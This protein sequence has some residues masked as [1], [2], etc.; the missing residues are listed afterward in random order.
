MDAIARELMTEAE[1][2]TTFQPLRPPAQQ[3]MLEERLRAVR[4]LLI[5]DNI[6]SVTGTHL[7]IRNTLPE[8]ER[9]LL[10]DFL[11]QLAGGRT[12]VLLGSRGGEDWLAQGTFEDNVHDLGGLHPEAASTLADRI[13]ERH[14][15][16]RYR[17]DEN[18]QWLLDL[19]AGYPMAMEVVLA[20]LARQTPTQVLDALRTGDEAI[21]MRSE[22]KTESILRCIDYS[23]SNLSSEAQ[24]LL[25]CL[26]PFTSVLNINMLS[27]Y[28]DQLRQQPALEHPCFDLWEQVLQEAGDW[29]LLAPHPRVKGFVRL[30][31]ILPYFLR[32]RLDNPDQAAIRSAIETAFR[33]HYDDMGRSIFGLLQSKVAGEK[34]VGQLLAQLEYNNLVTALNLALNDHVSIMNPY[35]ALSDYLHWTRD[36]RRGLELS[37]AVLAS[38][39]VFPSESLSGALARDLVAVLDNV[40]GL[41][42]LTK[43]YAD[44]EASYRKALSVCPDIKGVEPDEIR[45]STAS[46]YHQL[47]AVAYEQR[48]WSKAIHYYNESLKIKKEFG[49]RFEQA[50]T[51]HQ[52]GMVSREQGLWAKAEQY[53]QKALEIKIEFD[54]RYS[55]AT[56]Y[57]EL[58]SLAADQLRWQQAEQY[59]LKALEILIAFKDRHYEAAVYHGLGTVAAEQRDLRRAENYFQ[60]ALAIYIELNERYEQAGTYHMLGVVA[61]AQ[62]QWAQAKQYYQQALEIKIEFNDCYSQASTYGQLGLLAGDKGLWRQARQYLLQ[63]LE[64]FVSVGEADPTTLRSLTRLWLVSED[65]SL[66]AA[67]AQV[68][69][70]SQGEAEEL[71]LELASN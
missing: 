29:G 5:L 63:A 11:S 53:Y 61:Q 18:V 2:V 13:I 54:D 47:G 43:R 34:H 20:N 49:D 55:Q 24:Q 19:L 69:G 17:G 46:I 45:R 58:G 6:E 32:S 39:E 62:G 33:L 60:Q 31:P 9:E 68:M 8:D 66:P 15:A 67:V 22:K 28:T 3:A 40:A 10:H 36:H 26:A 50:G 71:L 44:A 16:T 52:L 41:Q 23:Y 42:L 27:R 59:Y 12:V 25:S 14:G 4:H 1:Y 57:Y 38:L 51:Y 65:N 21:D 56:T 70:V 30:Q 64:I 35:G 37:E 7:A 48:Q